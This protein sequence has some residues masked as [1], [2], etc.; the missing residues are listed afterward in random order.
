MAL[1]PEPDLGVKLKLLVVSTLEEDPEVRAAVE[2]RQLEGPLPPLPPP[3]FRAESDPAVEG[4]D[5]PRRYWYSSENIGLLV[6]LCRG[7]D[8]TSDRPSWNL[9]VCMSR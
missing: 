9:C 8:E 3:V 1:Y 6:A 7:S 5:G 4:G 2:E